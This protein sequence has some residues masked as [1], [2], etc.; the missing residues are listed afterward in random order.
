MIVQFQNGEK[1]S[2]IFFSILEQQFAK[3]GL[4]N[5][6]N[7]CPEVTLVPN[8]KA[9]D[10]KNSFYMLSKMGQIANKQMKTYLNPAENF[11]RHLLTQGSPSIYLL[12]TNERASL[13]P[14]LRW[15][16][17]G[18]PNRPDV[19]RYSKVVILIGAKGCGK[20]TLING[21]IN[22]ILGVQ[23]DDPFRFRIAK[24][25][26][27]TSVVTAYTIHHVQGMKIDYDLTLIDTP[28]YGD[29]GGLQRD[30]EITRII[31]RVL[32]HRHTQP[33]FN[34]IHAV[35]FVANSR[36]SVLTP[37]QQYAL[38]SAVSLFGRDIASS[39][40]LLVTFADGMEPPV[41]R[42]IKSAQIPGLSDGSIPHRK[43]NISA[44][45][46]SNSQQTDAND[47]RDLF[48][49]AFWELYKSNFEDFFSMLS[50]MPPQ[51]LQQTSVI[52]TTR[53]NLKRLLTEIDQKSKTVAWEEREYIKPLQQQIVQV[54][55]IVEAN[56]DYEVERMHSVQG[57]VA[58]DRWNVFLNCPTCKTTC[59]EHP[60]S[61]ITQVWR[62][63]VL[64]PCRNNSCS[65][66]AEH[67]EFHPF[68]WV[69]RQVQS[70]AIDPSM[71]EEYDRSLAQ[72]SSIENMLNSKEQELEAAKQKG[73]TLLRE[74]ANCLKDLESSAL[75]FKKS[76]VADL[77]GVLKM[78]NQEKKHP[79]WF[80]RNV[81]LDEM[82]RKMSE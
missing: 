21:M 12:K 34:A 76:T 63:G 28:S 23:W 61:C 56:K 70:T 48:G 60:K 65:C 19:K 7:M 77:V 4:I 78:R 2:L 67:H 51:S 35:C 47:D 14:E 54:S 20:S 18:K 49:K 8:K 55:A 73:V 45:Y 42:A 9:A 38:E 79:G 52:I 57:Q 40:R 25:D 31:G 22:H 29:A 33:G 53:S 1:L 3:T 41:L 32:T 26:F 39:V 71:K 59:G 6:P 16:D 74:L 17:V 58:C 80:A 72:K 81:I 64:V 75:S 10:L 37:A 43:F 69:V 27:Q 13:I 36:D 24:E 11:L 50:K 68:R 15:F 46:V 82:L 30:R 5:C 62:T 44:L 66:P